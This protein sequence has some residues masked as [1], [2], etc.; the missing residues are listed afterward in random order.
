MR[1]DGSVGKVLASKCE[2]LG[3]E[4]QNFYKKLGMR[5]GAY[6][7]IS[8]DTEMESRERWIPGDLGM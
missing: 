6:L 3:W 8:S 4:P 5:G 7:S 2:D 1:G